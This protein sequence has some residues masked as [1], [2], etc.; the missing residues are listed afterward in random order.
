MEEIF[1]ALGGLRNIK[2]ISNAVL[3]NEDIAS[4]EK[5][6]DSHLPDDYKSYLKD[7]GLKGF[8]ESVFFKPLNTE[9]IY[10][11]DEILGIP[12]FVFKG[13]YVDSFFGKV[14]N[15]PKDIFKNLN[16]YQDRIPKKCLPIGGD[17]LGNL[18]LIRLTENNYSNI[19]FWDHENEWDEED[20]E[21]ESEGRSFEENIKYQN[22]YLIGDN[23]SNFLERLEVKPEM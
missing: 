23:F 8:N 14:E 17:G 15:S 1:E 20:Y 12:N 19:L 22:T 16:M 18:I 21:E 11:H 4:I 2:N 9:A 7:Y 3:D 5:S 6:I 10:I 13:S